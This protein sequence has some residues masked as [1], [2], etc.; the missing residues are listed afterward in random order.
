MIGYAANRA[1]DPAAVFSEVADQLRRT[2]QFRESQLESFPWRRTYT[3]DEWV[4]E[5]QSHSDHAALAPDLRQRLLDAVGATI[6]E[7]GG[8]FDM[9]YVATVI[10]ADL[11]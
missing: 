3:R 5:L 1:G 2:G 4:D 6:D 7:F 9:A 11:A 10:S 8:R